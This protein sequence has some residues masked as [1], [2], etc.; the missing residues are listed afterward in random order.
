MVFPSF[1]YLAKDM[2]NKSI[3]NWRSQRGRNLTK[4]RGQRAVTGPA[5]ANGCGSFGAAA[6]LSDPQLS[7]LC[8]KG[9]AGKKTHK[10][11]Q[12]HERYRA[13]KI[14]TRVRAN[15]WQLK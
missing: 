2:I 5:P 7:P 8:R 12:K 6:P 15:E 3:R 10:G 4:Q 13:C 14:V 11:C 1:N 9:D